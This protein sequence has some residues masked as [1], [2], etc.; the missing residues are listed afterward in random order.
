MDPHKIALQTSHESVV[1]PVLAQEKRNIYLAAA[2][3]E[4]TLRRAIVEF[5]AE[6]KRLRVN[7]LQ[8]K[9]ASDADP[10]NPA[11]AA[12][13]AEAHYLYSVISEEH[14]KIWLDSQIKYTSMCRALLDY[15]FATCDEHGM[16]FVHVPLYRECT[17]HMCLCPRTS[18]GDI[19]CIRYPS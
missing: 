4:E 12:A 19:S 11:L 14:A 5:G 16:S 9:T 2:A 17:S 1:D 13:T 10:S 7:Y 15:K 3:E 8:K 18:T 6:Y